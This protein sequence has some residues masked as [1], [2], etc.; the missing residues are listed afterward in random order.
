[1]VAEVLAG[2]AALLVAVGELLH[3]RRCRRVAHLVF[4][5]RARPAPW[6]RLAPALRTAASAALAWGLLTLLW[7][8]PRIHQSESQ[9]DQEPQHLVLVLDVSPSMT[10]EDAGPDKT[11]T[12]RDRA[13]ELVDSLFSRV[14]IG[15][16]KISVVAVYNGAKP[17]VVD[18]EDREV[19]TNILADL[20]MHFAFRPGETKLLS[21]IETAA[22]I[23]RTWEAKSTLLVLVSDGDTVP[24]TGMPALPPSIHS[25]L[26]V[27]VGDP[28]AG[29][30]IDGRQS[31]Q[32]V[33]A[34][35]QIALRLGGHFHNGN[36]KHLSSAT[37]RAVSEAAGRTEVEQLT[38]REYAL[39][40]VA[41][42]A[43]LLALLP[44]LLH[45]AGT[46]WTP[47][48]RHIATDP[49]SHR[50]RNRPR[51]PIASRAA[52]QAQQPR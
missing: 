6:A 26:V 11:I 31:R 19:V 3:A 18:T 41:I 37:I 14:S 44:L 40:C 34:L 12:R 32:D 29:S 46:G 17:V 27:G 15:R 38:R 35:R 4:G 13:R 30:F 48:A 16:Y 39:I 51:P 36:A 42:G 25:V 5:P 8:E 49:T 23:A 45:Y 22:E 21:G 50:D 28:L 20:P 10:L 7:V 9:D 2:V 43:A 47:G 33:S 52:L 1:M 24:P